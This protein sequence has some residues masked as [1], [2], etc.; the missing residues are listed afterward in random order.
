[1]N[2]CP[3]CGLKYDVHFEPQSIGG[4]IRAEI[5]RRSGHSFE[6][7]A[8]QWAGAQA[9]ELARQPDPN[10]QDRNDVQP[11]TTIMRESPAW[12]PSIR[13]SVGVPF[14]EALVTG[15]LLG[16]SVCMLSLLTH[17][18]IWTSGGYG[19]ATAFIGV[20]YEWLKNRDHWRNVI[21]K[22][23][24]ITR[25]DFTRDGHLGNPSAP[26][27]TSS[28]DIP[29]GLH[30]TRRMSDNTIL[31]AVLMP[32]YPRYV[33]KAKLKKCARLYE[34]SGG[35]FSKRGCGS[36]F[37]DEI[38]DAQDELERL[39]YIEKAGK[40]ANAPRKWT[41]VGEHWL[42]TTPLLHS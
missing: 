38:A 16:G 7:V 9:T 31:Y 26:P 1:M 34:E 15:G 3:G 27:Q 22:I 37:G 39:G 23:E 25:I 11:G 8:G 20:S 24:E 41:G 18:G 6:S 19:L 4:S 29:H 5:E 2:K 28:I 17:G 30:I 21:F 32:D 14:T 36:P 33:V 42:K 10:H 12:E 13:G 35:N 40:A